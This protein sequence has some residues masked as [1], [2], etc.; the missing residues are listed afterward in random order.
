MP[1]NDMFFDNVISESEACLR[2]GMVKIE[3]CVT[4]LDSTQIWWRPRDEM[5]SIGN[6]ILHLAGN[7]RQWIVSGIGDQLDNRD[8]PAEFNERSNIPSVELLQHLS[9]AVEASCAVLQDSTADGLLVT[10]RIQGSN[11]TKLHAL[12]NS[13]THFQGHVQEIIGMTR[14]QL[15]D[16]YQYHWKPA[17]AEEGAGE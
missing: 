2:Y 17:T 12:F 7:L 4:Q 14:Q 6:L 8:R 13:V 1:L 11:V 3:H 5:N 10:K 15:G 16:A 9:S